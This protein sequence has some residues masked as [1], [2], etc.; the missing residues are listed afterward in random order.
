MCAM[1][2]VL[3]TLPSPLHSPTASCVA[4]SS[5]NVVATLAKFCVFG[6]SRYFHCSNI[7]S[8]KECGKYRCFREILKRHGG[9]AD[10]LFVVVGDGGEE[11]RAASNLE[12]PFISVQ[13]L[14]DLEDLED[15]LMEGFV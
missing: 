11:E 1:C 8:S 7:W 3:L 6:L 14:Q 12:L 5:S 15:A 9:H 4:V 10:T 13:G 2:E